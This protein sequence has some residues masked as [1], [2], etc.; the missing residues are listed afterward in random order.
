MRSQLPSWNL[1]IN[2]TYPTFFYCGAPG[3]CI[4]WAM[5]GAINAD[6]EHSIVTQIQSARVGLQSTKWSAPRERL[7]DSYVVPTRKRDTYCS[8][9]TVY[10]TMPPRPLRAF[11]QTTA[12]SPLRPPNPSMVRVLHFRMPE[13]RSLRSQ[14]ETGSSSRTPPVCRLGQ[15]RAS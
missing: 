15:S 5:V 10:H 2:T 4:N 14:Q 7:T 9:A 6:A 12:S 1:T 11:Q 13:V 3:S 8:Q